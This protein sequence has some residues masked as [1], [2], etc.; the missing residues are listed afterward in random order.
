M[1]KRKTSSVIFLPPR[2]TTPFVM[3]WKISSR[4]ASRQLLPADF[5]RRERGD[6]PFEP[7]IA[8]E[9][10]AK[11][12]QLRVAI[13]EVGV[14][15]LAASSPV[16]LERVAVSAAQ[17]TIS[18]ACSTERARPCRNESIQVPINRLRA[19]VRRFPPQSNWSE[20]R[21]ILMRRSALGTSPCSQPAIYF[22]SPAA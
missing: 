21:M 5:L 9:R 20:E 6:D 19:N 16:R 3:P 13:A 18:C 2:S 8:T 14:G 17:S 7:R 10:I 11:S 22:R 1:Q 4:A 12:Q 15:R